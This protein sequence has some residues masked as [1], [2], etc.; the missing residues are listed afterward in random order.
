MTIVITLIH[1]MI[2]MEEIEEIEENMLIF[3]RKMKR[4]VKVFNNRIKK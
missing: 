2:Q 1:L 4:K 3:S